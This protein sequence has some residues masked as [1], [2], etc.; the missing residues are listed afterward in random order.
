MSRRALISVGALALTSWLFRPKFLTQTI[1]ISGLALWTIS[2]GDAKAIKDQVNSWWTLFTI[3]DSFSK[4]SRD[5]IVL[6]P[7]RKNTEN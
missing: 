1:L 3:D 4:D 5:D 2:P 7:S 6:I